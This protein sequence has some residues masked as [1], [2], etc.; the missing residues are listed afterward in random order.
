[1]IK[2]WS[3]NTVTIKCGLKQAEE[4]SPALVEKDAICVTDQCIVQA[5]VGVVQ[6]ITHQVEVLVQ[7]LVE[8]HVAGDNGL[9]EEWLK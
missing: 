6:M 2:L 7:L 1:M 8:I 3:L 5:V 4:L 9:Q